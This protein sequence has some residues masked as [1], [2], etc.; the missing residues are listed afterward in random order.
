MIRPSD[1]SD[2]S[3]RGNMVYGTVA[4]TYDPASLGYPYY[5]GISARI[6]FYTCLRYWN[7]PTRNSKH[8]HLTDVAQPNSISAQN[9]DNQMGRISELLKWNEDYPIDEKELRRNDTLEKLGYARNPFIDHPEWVSKIW[10]V[11]VVTSD[12]D[13]CYYRVA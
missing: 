4:N 8:L 10:D 11:S 1:P 5:R 12:I 13:T 6:I 7:K 3:D 2:N 9:T